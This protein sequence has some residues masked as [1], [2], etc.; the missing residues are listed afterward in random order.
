MTT[1][2]HRWLPRI[3]L[4]HAAYDLVTGIWPIV[5]IRSFQKVTGPKA[6]LWLVKTVGLVVTVIGAVIGSAGIRKRITPEVAG[7]AIGSSAALAAIDVVYVGK[8]RIS[9]VYLLDV[10]MSVVLVGGWTLAIRRKLLP[11]R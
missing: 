9:P 4:L 6:D 10:L 5:D 3:W 2:L 8:G 1:L 11:H 7:L